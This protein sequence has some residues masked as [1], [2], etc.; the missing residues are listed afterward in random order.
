MFSLPLTSIL[1]DAAEEKLFKFVKLGRD[2]SQNNREVDL[3]VGLKVC[4][5]LVDV[6]LIYLNIVLFLQESRCYMLR[7]CLTSG[8]RSYTTSLYLRD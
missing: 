4:P 2:P 3:P 8:K 7:E 6:Q 5:V 1:E